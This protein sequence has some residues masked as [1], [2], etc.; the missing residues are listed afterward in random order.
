MRSQ[1][2]PFNFW[3][4]K[5][6]KLWQ[7]EA[8]LIIMIGI[9]KIE[10]KING[11]VYIGQSKNIEHR[12]KVHISRFKSKKY[13][14]KLYRAF[15]KYG[16]ENFKF[17]ILHECEEKQLDQLEMFYISK[18]NSYECGYNSTLGGGGAHV[19]NKVFTKETRAK[20]RYK[21]LHMTEEHKKKNSLSKQ[22]G[23]NPMARKVICDGIVFQSTK[24]CAQYYNI[25]PSTFHHYLSGRIK[26]PDRFKEFDLRYY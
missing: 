14:G 10:N 3:E 21:A 24:E 11:K 12:W 22:G 4:P 26:M 7:S 1:E 19:R 9:Y 8:K 18:Y 23:K 20:L 6:K 16:I 15:R 25:H 2:N 13:D 17:E 5:A